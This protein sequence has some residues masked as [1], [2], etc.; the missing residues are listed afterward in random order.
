MLRLH[1]YHHQP[2]IHRPG[3]EQAKPTKL[4]IDNLL[5]STHVLFIH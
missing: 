3:I 4:T 2:Y 1:Y 5:V